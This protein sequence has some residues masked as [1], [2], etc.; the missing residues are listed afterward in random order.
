MHN[1]K[2]NLMMIR[3]NKVLQKKILSDPKKAI[4]SKMNLN[5]IV[6]KLMHT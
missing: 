1:K 5:M 4:H 2:F 6:S 3:K